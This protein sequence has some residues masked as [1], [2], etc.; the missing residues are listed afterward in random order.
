MQQPDTTLLNTWHP[1]FSPAERSSWEELVQ[2]TNRHI[3]AKLDTRDLLSPGIISGDA[4]GILTLFHAAQHWDDE[5]LYDKAQGY[6]E[7]LIDGIDTSLPLSLCSGVAGVIWLLL[8]LD[9]EE[10]LEVEEDIISKEIIELLCNE[11]LQ[12]I[13]A[14]LYDYMHKGLGTTLALLCSPKHAF[15]YEDYF[16]QVI[17][18]L[19]ATAKHHKDGMYW[20]YPLQGKAG[21]DISLGMSHGLPSI[22]AIVAKIRALNISARN[23]DLL[24]EKTANFLLAHRNNGASISMYPSMV[25]LENPGDNFNSRLAWCYGDPG[26]AAAF[27]YAGKATGKKE[28]LEEA[29]RIINFIAQRNNESTWMNDGGF[30]HGTLGMAHIF[31]RFYQYKKDPVLKAK[32]I[33][34]FNRSLPMITRTADS[35]AVSMIEE[36]QLYWN[37]EPDLLQGVAGISATLLSSFAPVK[38][39]WDE[40]FLLDL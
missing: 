7:R 33:E 25:N 24:I 27:I 28:Y 29:D 15:R 37:G 1:C 21:N 10:I 39:S 22:M 3:T 12:Q 18:G 2:F 17:S 23:C 5:V 9:R 31:N 11:S 38:P 20:T 13:N 6:L 19:L 36:E 40:M 30:C 34:W 4:G 16:D 35:I 14:G 26:V 8:Y 32:A